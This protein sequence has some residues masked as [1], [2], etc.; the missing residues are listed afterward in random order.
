MSSRHVTI[1]IYAGDTTCIGDDLKHCPHLTTA[2][3]D[4]G[5]CHLFRDRVH[6]HLGGDRKGWLKRLRECV[7]SEEAG[8]GQ[9]EKE[10]EA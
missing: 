7:S 4:Y 8:P 10:N 2:V 5:T 6:P 1:P 9:T 3:G